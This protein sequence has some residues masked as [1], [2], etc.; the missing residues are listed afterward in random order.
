[1]PVSLRTPEMEDKYQK[2]L[3]TDLAKNCCFCRELDKHNSGYSSAVIK[4]YDCWVIMKNDFP[5]NMVYSVHNLLFPKRHVDFA[6][7][8]VKEISEYNRIL[9]EVR[10]DYHQQLENFGDRQSQKGHFHI[11]ICKFNE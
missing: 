8:T 5:Y 2:Y 7:L 11:H 6:D 10:K 3:K 1:M 4:E 9:N